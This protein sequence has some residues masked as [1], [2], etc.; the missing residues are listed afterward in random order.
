MWLVALDGQNR[1]RGERVVARGGHPALSITAREIL[2][3]ALAEGASGFLLVHNHPSGCATPSGADV[4]MTERV[5]RAA[6]V[7]GVPLLDHLVV[8]ASGAYCS[9]LEEGYLS[10]RDDGV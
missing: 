9:L 4:A 7:V 1:L 2:A 5:A 10:L 8:T 6:Q 3:A